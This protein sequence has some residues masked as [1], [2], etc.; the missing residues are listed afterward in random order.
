MRV[1]DLIG[2]DV[3]AVAHRS[4]TFIGRSDHPR[5]RGLAL[6]VWRLDDGSASLDAL[7]YQ[8]EVGEVISQPDG[9]LERL[10]R[11]LSGQEAEH[12]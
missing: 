7:D 11:A 10:E 3:V 9:R 2:G 6:V 12:G 4:A 5:Y 8:Q 1:C